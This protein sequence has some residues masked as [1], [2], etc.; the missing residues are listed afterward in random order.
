MPEITLFIPQLGVHHSPSHD[1]GLYLLFRYAKNIEDYGS[2][3]ARLESIFTTPGLRSYS[4][5]KSPFYS[6]LFQTRAWISQVLI[7]MAG[8]TPP[9]PFVVPARTA[10]AMSQ[11]APDLTL[12][13]HKHLW[14]M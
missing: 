14:R 7:T 12:S 4:P 13:L 9:F 10:A 5:V 8:V 1:G 3:Q 11:A 2:E 6:F